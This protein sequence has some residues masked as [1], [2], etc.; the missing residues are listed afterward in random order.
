M[1][2]VL[3]LMTNFFTRGEMKKIFA[4]VL[5]LLYLA[6]SSGATINFHYCMGKFIGW[7][8]AAAPSTCSNCGMKK[9]N[10]KDCCNDKHTIIQLQK[11][12]LSSTINNVP[13]NPLVYI[14]PKYSSLII[15]SSSV[16]DKVIQLT[17]RPPLIQSVSAN[18]LYCV[19]RI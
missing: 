14:Q 12:Q 7:D 9:E 15:S 16:N 5:F 18:V 10:K 4:I 3:E 6:T 8:I 13:N 1:K 2:F 11:A 17:H 19:F